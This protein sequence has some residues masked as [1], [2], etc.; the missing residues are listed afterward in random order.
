V[1]FAVW[2]L[3]GS[4][5]SLGPALP[6]T[7]VHSR[8]TLDGGRRR[9]ILAGVAAASVLALRD[10][11]TRTVVYTGVLA[12]I[13]VGVTLVSIAAASAAVSPPARSRRP[14]FR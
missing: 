12:L 5:G 8:S 9:F 14:R 7:L 10:T 4:C 11:A 3:A 6:G 2:A 13:I 1:L